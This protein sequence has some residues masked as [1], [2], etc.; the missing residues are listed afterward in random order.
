[1]LQ[2]HEHE[3]ID[4]ACLPADLYH[5]AKQTRRLIVVEVFGKALRDA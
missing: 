3:P 1:M 5:S 2:L 4:M